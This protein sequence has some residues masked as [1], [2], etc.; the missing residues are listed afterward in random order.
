MIDP[1][2]LSLAQGNWAE[3]YRLRHQLR[4]RPDSHAQ[5]E[6]RSKNYQ[7][8]CGQGAYTEA[9]ISKLKLESLCQSLQKESLRIL[10]IGCGPGTLA[11]PLA[12][13]GH[14]LSCLDFSKA[15]LNVLEKRAQEAHLCDKIT[16]IHGSWDDD[17]ST[18]GIE[19]G[20]DLLIASRSAIVPDLEWA[21]KKLSSYAASKVAITMVGGLSPKFDEKLARH[22]GQPVAR[23]LDS[24]YA[25]NILLQ[26]GYLPEMSFISVQRQS[27]Y[28]TKAQAYESAREQLGGSLS[29]EQECKLKAYMDE[30]LIKDES[31]AEEPWLKNYI[32]K[33]L[34][35]YISW[36]PSSQYF[37]D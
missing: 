15:M 11:L 34:W 31:Q 32:H 27:R 19:P 29:H 24:Q 5:W 13:A 4:K 6:K 3:E 16:C 28:E 25:I 7:E 37:D 8:N 2:L 35:A 22:F 21:F 14:E 26:M 12:A 20:F 10:D 1:S 9:F 33:V 30:H 36:D 18:L 17:W 23:G